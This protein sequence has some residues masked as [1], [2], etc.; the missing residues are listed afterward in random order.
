MKKVVDSNR[1]SNGIR[2]LFGFAGLIIAA[3]LPF[4]LYVE[5]RK[6]YWDKKVAELCEREGGIKVFRPVEMDRNE[7]SALLNRQNQIE[8]PSDRSAS[9][10]AKYVHSTK[11]EYLVRGHLEVRRYV[12]Q[13]LRRPSSEVLSEKVA[14]SRVGGDFLAIDHSTSFSCPG[15]SESPF[16]KT[17]IRR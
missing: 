3:V 11:T 6:A 5:G 7:Y 13:V 1:K 10:D 2:W 12:T 16:A 15:Q 9:P 14:F 8:L 17:F 4:V